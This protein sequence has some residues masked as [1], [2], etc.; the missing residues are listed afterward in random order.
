MDELLPLGESASSRMVPEPFVDELVFA[1]F[2]GLL[3]IE[4]RFTGVDSVESGR[5]GDLTAIDDFKGLSYRAIFFA[6]DPYRLSAFVGSFSFDDAF[7]D[8]L[9][10]GAG[11]DLADSPG[12]LWKARFGRGLTGRSGFGVVSLG[13]NMVNVGCSFPEP[14]EV[15]PPPLESSLGRRLRS[16]KR[17]GDGGCFSDSVDTSEAILVFGFSFGSADCCAGAGIV[18][19]FMSFPF[20][21]ATAPAGTRGSF[22]ALQS[23]ATAGSFVVPLSGTVVSDAREEAREAPLEGR[24]IAELEVGMELRVLDC[25]L[26][27]LRLV[28]VRDGMMP[29]NSARAD[30]G[31]VGLAGGAKPEVAAEPTL[32]LSTSARALPIERVMFTLD[33][34][35]SRAAIVEGRLN[36]A[37]RAPARC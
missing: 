28:D 8:D 35:R 17:T 27:L 2:T 9:G 1:A 23:S 32:L 24:V 12:G 37:R 3:D 16:P 7:G 19:D 15:V 10:T 13:D 4:A 21:F 18:G 11:G 29:P 14:F 5:V 31:I 26:F 22:L 6:G 33:A 34:L 25:K 20:A 30:G 36:S